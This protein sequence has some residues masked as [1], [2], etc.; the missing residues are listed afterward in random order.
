MDLWSRLLAVGVAGSAMMALGVGAM[1]CSA[2][3]ERSDR[4]KRP[5][6]AVG[7]I[8]AQSVRLTLPD[9]VGVLQG[10]RERILAF[11]V[12]GR[13]ESI[14]SSGS[15][16]KAGE[17]IAALGASLERARLEKAELELAQTRTEWQ[18]IQE[19][20]DESATSQKAVDRADTSLRIRQAERDIAAEHL[21]RRS[22]V[23]AFDGVVVD[24]QPEVGEVVNPGVRIATLMSLDPMR[25]EIG[26]PGYQIG[27]VHAGAEVSLSVPAL[28][29][30]RFDAVVSA[31]A[32]AAVGGGHLFE[33]EIRV[34]NP[35]GRL[36]PGM[37]ARAEIVTATLEDVL[38]V[39]VDLVVERKSRRVV[40]FVSDHR[41]R[42]VDVSDA[43]IQ[44]DRVLIPSS[45]GWSSLVLRGQRELR[46][47]HLVKIHNAILEGGPGA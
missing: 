18:R 34:Q 16:V 41:A 36:R 4:S 28:S 29:G 26:V 32:P 15:E 21:T 8:H 10:G 46:D 37:D 24:N 23:A 38:A 45:V 19:L 1:P 20:H 2:E 44:R 7:E 25:L 39:P 43:P 30:E 9:K 22:L 33:V 42:A 12:G 17:I 27:R 14:G 13:L 40:F 6:V 3:S 5:L 47:A 11:E 35:D 31:V